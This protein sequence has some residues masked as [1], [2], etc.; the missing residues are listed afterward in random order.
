MRP[1]ETRAYVPD[2]PR[3]VNWKMRAPFEGRQATSPERERGRELALERFA[4][5]SAARRA[6]R[7]QPR[8][9]RSGCRGCGR[10]RRQA[11]AATAATTEPSVLTG[12]LGEG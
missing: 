1:D 11:R 12:T 4:A 9:R 2:R 7:S 8:M 3:L 10:R 5:P 6:R